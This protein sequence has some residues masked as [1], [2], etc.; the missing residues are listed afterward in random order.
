MGETR[1]GSIVFWVVCLG[2]LSC[3]TEPEPSVGPRARGLGSLPSIQAVSAPLP[4]AHCEVEVDGVGLLDLEA[5]YLP[6]VIACENN[7]ANLEALEAQAI[8][9]RS[10][11]YY[12][13]ETSGS[14]CDSQGCQVFTCGIEAGPIHHRAVEETSGQYL[15]YNAI[16]TYGFY[17][18]G[19]NS[20]V[21]PDCVGNDANA[22]TEHW[23]TYNEGKTGELV[24]QTELGFVHQPGDSGYGQNRG[25]MSQWG[26]RCLENELGYDAEGIL[27]VY[28]GDDIEVLK[29]EGP[30][31][32]PD[33]ASTTSGSGDTSGGQSTT[34]ASWGGSGS[35]EPG[36]TG[37][38]EPG[39]TSS[40]TGHQS[41]TDAGSPALPEFGEET[42]DG[43]GCATARPLSL[44]TG[45]PLILLTALRRRRRARRVSGSAS[46]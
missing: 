13:I 7:G 36:S 45:W 44:A 8:A 11:A 46:R 28:Y 31:V 21:P 43:C 23:V 41:G 27:R 16:L 18:A 14:I 42:E 25:C 39:T 17:V 9:A 3:T 34:G 20:V 2:L 35:G 15:S 26:G 19:D 38:L 12:S 40:E 29:A 32:M 37:L 24:E 30:C 6:Q 10:V 1:L 22:A 4:A 5:D 33:P